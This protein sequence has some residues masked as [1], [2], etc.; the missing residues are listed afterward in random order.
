MIRRSLSIKTCQQVPCPSPAKKLTC[1]TVTCPSPVHGPWRL[2]SPFPKISPSQSLCAGTPGARQRVLFCVRVVTKTL[3]PP[4]GANET[5]SYLCVITLC[6]NRIAIRT[7]AG[8]SLSL[9]RR[10]GY[11]KGVVAAS[12]V[13][14]AYGPKMMQI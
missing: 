14:Y 5:L 3:A 1:R 13:Y 11:M 8:K 4:L 12:Q 6:A 7:N 10:Q 9:H 2:A